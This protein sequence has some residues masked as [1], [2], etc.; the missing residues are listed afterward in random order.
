M[1]LTVFN[2]DSHAE[3]IFSIYPFKQ[4]YNKDVE[5]S[6]TEQKCYN[7]SIMTSNNLNNTLCSQKERNRGWSEGDITDQTSGT[8]GN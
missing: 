4:H 2:I 6:L 1:I 7:D 5:D 8:L 3:N